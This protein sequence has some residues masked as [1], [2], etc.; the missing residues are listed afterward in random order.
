MMEFLG[1]TPMLK[2]AAGQERQDA[3]EPPDEEQSLR[4]FSGLQALMPG[5]TRMPPHL[6]TAIDWAEGEKTKRGIN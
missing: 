4:Q 1:K 3:W 2:M 5:I 6:R